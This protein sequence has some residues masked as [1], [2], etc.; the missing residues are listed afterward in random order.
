MRSIIKPTI[1]LFVICLVVTAALAYTHAITKD[2]IAERAALDAE[3]A[4]REVLA[5]ADSFSRVESIERFINEN[6]ELDIVKEVYEGIKDNVSVG[7]VFLVVSKG[8][9]G[10]MEVTV[11]INNKGEITGVKIGN[12]SETPGL[13]LKVTD[14]AFTS[15]FAGFAPSEPLQVVKREKVKKEEIEAISSA[16][17][18]TRA[19]T[20]AVQAAVDM[21][22]QL[23]EEGGKAG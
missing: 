7:Y 1:V 17:I 6:P 9:G 4:R 21:A 20:R 22:S 15:Q 12:N 2:K 11:G 5:D 19:V 10:D 3:N 16:T 23:L 13:G 8:Y 18:S 14:E